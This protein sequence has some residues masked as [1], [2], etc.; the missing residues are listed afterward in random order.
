MSTKTRILLIYTGGTIGMVQDHRDGLLHPFGFETLLENI[1][2]LRRFDVD[3]KTIQLSRI[4][5]SSD[6]EPA[7]WQELMDR[8]Q[9]QY[10]EFDGFVILHGTDTLAFTASAL[11]F[12]IQGLDKPIV[13]TGSQL[14]IGTI[15]TDGKENLIT[16]IEVAA[17]KAADKAMVPEV[18]V[19]FEYTLLR[20]NRVT[21]YS[22]EHFDAFHSPNYPELAEAGIQIVYNEPYILESCSAGPKFFRE[23][24]SRIAVLKLF[25]GIDPELVRS[26]LFC[27]AKGL[28]MET[29]GAGN[30]PRAPWFIDLLMEAIA[31]G[32]IILNVTQCLSGTVQHGRYATSGRFDEIG[33]ISGKDIR[34]EAAVCKMMHALGQS[35]DPI[36]VKKILKSVIAG[37]MTEV[38]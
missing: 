14:P 2:E 20:G 31:D 12:M 7:I 16:A 37:E 34:F 27:G 10:D 18:S 33:V 32:L 11:S 19:Y 15:R 24:D 1:P 28:I 23:M 38:K 17:T 22:A 21:K 6:M 3:I 30:A 26:I 4:I 36:E 5:D 35:E 25:P 8:I 29:Y 9:E 13:L